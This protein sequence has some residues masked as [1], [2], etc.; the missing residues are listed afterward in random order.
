MRILRQSHKHNVR[1]LC[2]TLTLLAA[3]A[4]FLSF[5]LIGCSRDN[6]QQAVPSEN[7]SGFE[8]GPTLSWTVIIIGAAVLAAIIA[9]LIT[10][11]MVE[12]R[13]P[14][15]YRDSTYLRM[16][17]ERTLDELNAIRKKYR[18]SEN[19]ER[20]V[21]NLRNQYDH[22]GAEVKRLFPL[23]MDTNLREVLSKPGDN[24]W[25][26]SAQ[27]QAVKAIRDYFDAE[28][29]KG[30]TLREECSTLASQIREDEPAL[31]DTLQTAINSAGVAGLNALK[32]VLGRM[33]QQATKTDI[34]AQVK[35]DLAQLE[36]SLDSVTDYSYRLV[37]MRLIKFARDLVETPG[38]AK[39]NRLSEKIVRQIID[40]CKEY[41]RV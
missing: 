23:V 31:F 28:I 15:D 14:D 32:P 38:S 40:L 1:S 27:I 6:A 24:Y 35:D 2:L 29:K 8:S 10:L 19:L 11:L 25:T 36:K 12:R 13:R 37:P 33:A 16:Q 22:V 20:Q 3:T 21:P 30:K 5:S 39:E 7:I 41:L 18:N 34:S 17:L 26:L 9:V 4:L